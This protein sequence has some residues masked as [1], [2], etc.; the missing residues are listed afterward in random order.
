MVHRHEFLQRVLQARLARAGF[1]AGRVEAF[2]NRHRP[3]AM[4]IQQR[5]H[6]RIPV[7]AIIHGAPESP[8]QRNVIGV[9]L[10]ARHHGHRLG[11]HGEFAGVELRLDVVVAQQHIAV[12]A[13]E[14]VSVARL[15]FAEGG[16]NLLEP[17]AFGD[18]GGLIARRQKFG[19]PHGHGVGIGQAADGDD[20]K[21]EEF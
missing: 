19:L 2:E 12:K 1:A 21:A 15:G 7:L 13:E 10:V 14:I 8:G 16:L 11:E 17:R 9:V 4:R 6:R 20:G 3:A 18:V 5:A